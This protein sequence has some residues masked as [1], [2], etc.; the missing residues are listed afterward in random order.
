MTL[1]AVFYGAESDAEGRQRLRAPWRIAIFLLLLSLFTAIATLAIVAALTALHLTN[2]SEPGIFVSSLG[3]C[4][5]LIGAHAA[6]LRVDRRS[7]DSIGLGAE[8]ARPRTLLRGWWLGVLCI[9]VP[10]LVLLGIGWLAVLPAEDAS[11]LRAAAAVSV[12]LLPAALA[13]EL[14]MRGYVFAALR[15]WIGVIPTVALTSILFGLG[16]LNNPGANAVSVV[17]VILAGV[18]L[19]CVLVAT[20]SLYA[21]WMAHWAWNWTMAVLLHIAVSGVNFS[22][23]DY[24]V[25]DS[26]PDWITGGP[27]GPEGGAAG[28]VGMLGGLAYLYFRRNA[29]LARSH[30]ESS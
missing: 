29:L 3:L 21:A 15:E 22:Q 2:T 23:P 11:L 24:R 6:M 20:R 30:A 4:L 9:A 1:R 17:M 10:S 8:A 7:W 16:H 5:G 19:A 26:G 14:L 27:W 12:I 25:V 18:F 28:A 13:E